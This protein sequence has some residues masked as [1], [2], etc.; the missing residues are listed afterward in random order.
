[1][2]SEE[3]IEEEGEEEEDG[4]VVRG[5]NFVFLLKGGG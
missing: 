3:A 5:Y 4:E 2:A 1:V